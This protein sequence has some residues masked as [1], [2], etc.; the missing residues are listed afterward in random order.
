MKGVVESLYRALKAEP[1]VEREA[2]PFLYPG[3]AARLDE[4]WLGEL[5]PSVLDGTWGVFELEL[6][7][8]LAASREPIQYE[9]VI[10]YPAVNQDLAFAVD[11]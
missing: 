2:R 7:A 8:L 11:E 1:H 6:D 5:H 10:T 4:G 3:R 9:D